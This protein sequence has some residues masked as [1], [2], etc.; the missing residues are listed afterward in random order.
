[1]PV[2]HV[3]FNKPC[4]QCG[5][6]KA[7]FEDDHSNP[8]H[9]FMLSCYVC[10]HI[11][12]VGD[13]LMKAAL[14]F[15]FGNAKH[16]GQ[17]GQHKPN[18]ITNPPWQGWQNK[19]NKKVGEPKKTYTMMEAYEANKASETCVVCGK[20]LNFHPSVSVKYCSCIESLPKERCA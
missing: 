18:R 19:K 8:N 14:L 1:M 5:S 7:L 16:F 10:G 15:K 2:S 20:T 3:L 4:P 6:D 9:P 13:D 11:K 12:Y 17:T